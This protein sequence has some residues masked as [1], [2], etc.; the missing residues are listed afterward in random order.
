M[1]RSLLTSCVGVFL[2][3]AYIVTIRGQDEPPVSPPTPPLVQPLPEEA[4]WALAVQES[5]PDTQAQ[6]SPAASK[7]TLPPKL[8]LVSVDVVKT[9]ELKRDIRTYEDGHVVEVW[10]HNSI[11]LFPDSNGQPA[12]FDLKPMGNSALLEDPVRSTGYTGIG[13]IDL[14]NYDRVVAFNGQPAY[15]YHAALASQ[16]SPPFSGKSPAQ[17]QATLDAWI[18]VKTGRPLGYTDARGRTFTY[19]FSALPSASLVLPSAY[20]AILTTY[21]AA[22]EK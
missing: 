20:A 15:H 1:S 6:P 16:A 21:M 7:A 13:W 8:K 2:L 4:H 19:T 14:K 9:G 5:Q 17:S 12:I 18:D 11:Y 22:R 3:M 10:F